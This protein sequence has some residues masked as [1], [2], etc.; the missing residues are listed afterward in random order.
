MYPAGLVLELKTNNLYY[1]NTYTLK[2]SQG[3]ILVS[4]T[5]FL[6]N[7]TIRDTVNLASDCYTLTMTDAGGDGLSFWNNPGQ[8]AGHFYIRDVSTGAVLKNFNPDFG[9]GFI[10]Q[11]TVGFALPVSETVVTAIESFMIYPNPADNNVSAS[12]SLPSNT[13][14]KLSL[15][16]MLGEAMATETIKVT[17]DVEKIN[18]DITRFSNGAYFMLLEAGNF[19]KAQKLIIAR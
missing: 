4:T 19:H 6:S 17:N 2:D 5:G 14:A 10:Q 13:S 11:F 9:N 15:M 18:F 3:N 7:D 1:Q 12:F 16:N 8:G